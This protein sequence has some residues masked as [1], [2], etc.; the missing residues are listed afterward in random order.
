MRKFVYTF[1]VYLMRDDLLYSPSYVW[2]VV[3]RSYDKGIGYT[4]LAQSEIVRFWRSRIGPVMMNWWGWYRR[5]LSTHHSECHM[6]LRLL[7]Y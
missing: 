4:I 2:A 1:R 6:H 7:R 5:H 3:I